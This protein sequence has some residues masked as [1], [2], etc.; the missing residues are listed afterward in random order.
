MVLVRVAFGDESLR[1]KLIALDALWRPKVRLRELPW[2]T[3]RA[4]GIED[5]VVVSS[6]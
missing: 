2:G 3:V 4:L 5:R 6:R 1:A